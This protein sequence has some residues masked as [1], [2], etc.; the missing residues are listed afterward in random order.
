M[1]MSDP[2]N[3]E[4]GS[5]NRNKF[6]REPSALGKKCPGIKWTD[7]FHGLVRC[8]YMCLLFVV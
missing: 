5:E 4:R 3:L 1:K 7:V 6:M 8:I 2:N